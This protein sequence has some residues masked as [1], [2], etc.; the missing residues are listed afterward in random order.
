MSEQRRLFFPS[1]PSTASFFFLHGYY[2]QKAIFKMKK[3]KTLF[4]SVTT[5]Q[6]EILVQFWQLNITWMHECPFC[7][8]I[9]LCF[10]EFGIFHFDVIIQKEI[11]T[12]FLFLETKKKNKE[13]KRKE[14]FFVLT[15]VW[16]N[17]K[18]LS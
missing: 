12:I 11:L 3:I 14:Q 4:N 8:I 16:Q 2:P 6:N 1:S 7:L 10:H 18:F 15:N 17:L 5:G 13:K 9:S